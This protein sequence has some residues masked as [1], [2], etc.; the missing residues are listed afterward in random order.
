[1][2]NL[3]LKQ[4]VAIIGAGPTGLA[5]AAHLAARKIPFQIFEASK[6]VG[7]NLLD[8]GHVRVFT[9][10][11]YILDK[12]AEKLLT[13]SNWIKPEEDLLPTGK[14]IVQEYLEPL[15]KLPL[16]RENI[17]LNSPVLSVSRKRLS[18]IQTQN[19][20]DFPFILNVRNNG[21][22]ISFEASAIIDASGTWQ[23]HNPI[24]SGGV[25]AVGEL[26]NE[27]KIAYRIPD[28]KG[29]DLNRYANKS[30]VVIG[31][32]H[33]A[34]NSLLDLAELKKSHPKTKLHWILQTPELSKVYGGKEEDKL[35]ER[36]ALGSR[37]E[38]LVNERILKIHT[39][40]FIDQIL[41]VN[42]KLKLIGKSDS[43]NWTLD[44]VDEIIANTGGRPDFSF[45]REV[46]Y[47]ADPT[48]ESVP[49]LADLIDPNI[50][51]CGTVRPHGEL[52]L[53]QP[54]TNFYIVGVKS[55]GRAPTFLMPTGYE[56]VRSIVAWLAG[57][58]EAARRV[59]LDLPETGV[60]N[61]DFS[62]DGS[63]CAP[64][65]TNK[66]CASNSCCGNDKPK[67]EANKATQE[68]GCCAPS[69]KKTD[70]SNKEVET[71]DVKS[72]SCC[73]SPSAEVV[74]VKKAR[75]SCCG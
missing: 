3:K 74:E 50:H 38:A 17:Y 22:V 54:E 61:S 60:C 48:V 20:E 46:R 68:N 71:V 19:R 64:S 16:F 26:E 65:S 43:P 45:L 11:K 69:E 35:K 41:R 53:K 72:S 57:D 51:S 25:F 23:N 58:V 55:Y 67:E 27:D 34:I 75:V 29:A 1:M 73:G 13:E 8:W 56:Q 70:E 28:L 15:T 42:E 32:G 30:V 44:E 18:K 21:E 59:E 36:G 37:I 6:N 49:D 24:G 14:E 2:S 7:A 47:Q 10:W 62:L 52:E 31:G 9:P 4:P 33:S 12:A 63:C 39:P 40:V 66:E 5:A